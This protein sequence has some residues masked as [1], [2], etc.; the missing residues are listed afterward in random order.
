MS[1][2]GNVPVRMSKGDM[3]AISSLGIPYSISFRF[4]AASVTAKP[5]LT[6]SSTRHMDRTGPSCGRQC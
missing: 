6:V 5:A 1:R 4:V 2:K 3:R